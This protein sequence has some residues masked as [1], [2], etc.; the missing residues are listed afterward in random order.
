MRVLSRDS[1]LH[2]LRVAVQDRPE[3]YARSLGH[4]GEPEDG[5]AKEKQ[6]VGS[7]DFSPAGFRR[8]C[9]ALANSMLMQ[10]RKL[11]RGPVGE[12]RRGQRSTGVLSKRKERSGNV[13]GEGERAESSVWRPIDRNMP[14]SY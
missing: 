7:L 4:S 13:H 3:K 1:A 6:D 2:E 8:L 9:A 14:S 10:V 12:F 5:P 11:V